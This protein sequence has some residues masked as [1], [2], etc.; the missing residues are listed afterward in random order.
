MFIATRSRS[1]IQVHHNTIGQICDGEKDR[2]IQERVGDRQMSRA[3]SQYLVTNMGYAHTNSLMKR[4]MTLPKDSRRHDPTSL[5]NYM[6]AR[7]TRIFG[8]RS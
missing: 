7:C 5:W 3:L 4:L 2:H 1:V 8:P 6:T